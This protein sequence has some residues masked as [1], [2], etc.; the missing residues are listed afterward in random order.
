MKKRKVLKCHPAAE[1]FPP[2]DAIETE[3]P[4]I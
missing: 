2:G 1:L 3:G 4:K